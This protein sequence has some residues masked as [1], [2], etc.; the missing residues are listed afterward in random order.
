MNKH[1]NAFDDVASASTDNNKKRQKKAKN[2]QWL[3]KFIRKPSE[4]V[5]STN[6]W[7]TEY[8]Q[9]AKQ[10][11]AQFDQ[12]NAGY[13]EFGLKSSAGF[14]C[15]TKKASRSERGRPWPVEK[16]Y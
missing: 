6:G 13:F 16:V 5:S 14:G 1:M 3:A 11:D 2:A 7:K 9:K 4:L 15:R 10:I 8:C 12:Q